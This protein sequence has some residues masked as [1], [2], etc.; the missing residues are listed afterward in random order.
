MNVDKP[1][2]D[3]GGA[4]RNVHE[5]YSLAGQDVPTPERSARGVRPPRQIPPRVGDGDGPPIVVEKPADGILRARR[6]ARS[7]G[8]DLLKRSATGRDRRV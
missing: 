5:P 6:T 1:L 4:I 3:H 2:A 8:L 7:A